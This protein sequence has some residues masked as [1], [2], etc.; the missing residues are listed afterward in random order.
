MI[1]IVVRAGFDFSAMTH[2]LQNYARNKLGERI[3]KNHCPVLYSPCYTEAM[4][5]AKSLIARGVTRLNVKDN[6]ES[7]VADDD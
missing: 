5:E 1:I 6:C 7:A 4:W 3:Y 2:A